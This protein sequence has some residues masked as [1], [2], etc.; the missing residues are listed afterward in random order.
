MTRFVLTALIFSGTILAAQTPVPPPATQ[1]PSPM[2]E[3]TRAHNRLVARDLPGVHRT[4]TGP[5]GKPV[6]VYV[7][8][9]ATRAKSVHLVIHFHGAAFVAEQAVAT[10]GHDH[11]SAVLNLGVGSGVYDRALSEPAAFDSLLSSILRELDEGV[12]HPVRIADI[13][14]SGWS[15]GYGSIRAI[16]RDTIN[17][18][19]VSAV[20]LLDGLHVSYVPEATVVEKGGVLDSTNL[21]VFV[22][23]AREAMRG[24]KRFVLTHSEIFPGTFASTTETTDYLVRTLG[25]R[26][27][28]VLRW[29]PVGMQ[30]LSDARSGGLTIMGF[31]GNTAPDHV[32][33]VHGMATFLRL[34]RGIR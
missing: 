2:V 17:V 31:A 15:A 14:L 9:A 10:L 32:D 8:D 24:S 21:D 19:R 6:A 3:T 12:G 16:L 20:L 34:A 5:L 25:L 11:V 27:V 7:P 22:R 30:Q 23:F 18:S 13:T 28:A 26:R 29:G 33:H 1:N 4:F